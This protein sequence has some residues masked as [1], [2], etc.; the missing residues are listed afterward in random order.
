MCQTRGWYPRCYPPFEAAAIRTYRSDE[1]RALDRPVG[2]LG[3]RGSKSPPLYH[4]W[5]ERL[6]RR[7]QRTLDFNPHPPDP[8]GLA[9]WA[10]E[11]R[12]AGERLSELEVLSVLLPWYVF[13]RPLDERGEWFV[14]ERRREPNHGQGRAMHFP[15]D[16]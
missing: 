15:V 9:G 12:R 3:A 1:F 7:V 16:G 5:V 13:Q 10:G 11:Q 14:E 6:R 8:P 2:S 4:S